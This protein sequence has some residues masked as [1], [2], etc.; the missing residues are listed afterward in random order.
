MKN[1]MFFFLL[2]VS[3][4]LSAQFVYTIKAD[5]T[6]LTGCDSNELIIEN[7]TQGVP[8]F[9]YNTGK[10]RTAF[11]RPLTK[12]NDTFYLVGAD[13]LKLRNPN[14]WVQGLNAFGTTGMLGTKDNQPLDI[15]AG[16][17]RGAR[18]TNRGHLLLGT[19]TDS[20]FRLDMT[21]SQRIVS[22][23]NGGLRV[24]AASDQ[25][26]IALVPDYINSAMISFGSIAASITVNKQPIHNIPAY[27]LLI[28]GIS[29]TRI[30]ALTS[31]TSNPVFV[32]NGSGNAT[33]NGGYNGIVLGDSGVVANSSAPAFNVNGG[34][35]TGTGFTGDIIFST[36]NSQASGATVHTLTNRWWLKGG[37]GYFSN[38]S[39]PTSS[40]DVS[41]ANGYSQF[42]MRTT[43]TPT[44]SSDTNG[45]TGDFSWDGNYFYIKTA[46]GWKRAALTTF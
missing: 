46:T 16:N 41:N 37:T 43:Y 22:P 13:T 19:T 26:N 30:V 34:I 25:F 4:H 11:K 42:R 17:Q 12:I 10:G 29:P 36:G 39:S 9:L 35:G 32:V 8:G 18:F 14:A 5:S 45:N 1:T 23:V 3:S 15:Y 6:K 2:L 44:S 20:T 38:T 28:G 21:G 7:H 33:I 40:V 31:Y 24:S 27:S